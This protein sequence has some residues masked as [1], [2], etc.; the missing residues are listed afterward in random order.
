MRVCVQV[1]CTHVI[2]LL[3]YYK[4][5]PL[6]TART[7]TKP[8]VLLEELCCAWSPSHEAQL[9]CRGDKLRRHGVLISLD[10]TFRELRVW[11]SRASAALGVHADRASR[12]MRLSDCGLWSREFG[13]DVCLVRKLS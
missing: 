1:Y 2:I 13:R 8:G 11:S 9:V 7:C 6:M 12:L 5:M 3:S 4:P 10:C